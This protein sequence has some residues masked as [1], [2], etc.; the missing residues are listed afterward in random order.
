MSEEV[1]ERAPGKLTPRKKK[2]KKSSLGFTSRR[3][4]HFCNLLLLRHAGRHGNADSGRQPIVGEVNNNKEEESH[5]CLHHIIKPIKII[6]KSLHDIGRPILFLPLVLQKDR[7]YSFLWF[8]RKTDS[9]PSSGSTGRPILFLPLVLQKDRFYSFLWFYRKTDS[10]PSSGSTERPI[11]FLPLVL[12]KDR[13]YSFLWFY[14]KTDSIPSSGST[15]RPILFLPL[16]LQKDR[17]YSFL[18]F[19]RKTDSIPS[20]GST[21]RPILF[22]PLVLQ[23]DRFYSF[24]WFYRKT[25]SIPSSGSTERPILFLPLVLLSLR[26]CC[27][28]RM[29]VIQSANY[30]YYFS[31]LPID[32]ANHSL[33]LRSRGHSMAMITCLTDAHISKKT[34]NK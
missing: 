4:V 24:L 19:Y 10:I 23:K 14:R 34:M 3:H 12:Q 11:L 32:I 28:H 26:C 20:S 9:I 25:D 1:K 7:F 31:R 17:F 16:V 30:R 6:P 21:E 27:C 18:W 22:L 2:G 33:P 8:Y 29:Q 5:V 15:E 13:L